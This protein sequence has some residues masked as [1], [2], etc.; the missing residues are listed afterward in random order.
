MVDRGIL[1]LQKDSHSLSYT[2]TLYAREITKEQEIK[3]EQDGCAK[4]HYGFVKSP[5][6]P[7]IL[8]LGM[9]QEINLE[10]LAKDIDYFEKELRENLNG[11]LDTLMLI[12]EMK[13]YP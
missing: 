13:C 10:L 9:G 1:Y 4:G 6:S 12:I 5:L 11:S 2:N 3:R 7:E 8:K